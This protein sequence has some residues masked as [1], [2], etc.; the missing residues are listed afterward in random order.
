MSDR[1]IRGLGRGR[2]YTGLGRGG[3]CTGLGFTT[4]HISIYIRWVFSNFNGTGLYPGR[5]SGRVSDFFIKSGPDPD[6]L[7]IFLKTHTR[8]YSLSDRVKSGPLG[9][10]RAEYPW[11]GQKLSSLGTTNK[12]LF[13]LFFILYYFF[14]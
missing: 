6:P 5:V 2:W 11:V 3:W 10:D 1:E 12:F 7:R 9:S 14:I 13:L 8:S 4:K